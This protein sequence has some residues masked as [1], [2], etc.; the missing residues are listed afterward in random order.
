MS[1]I[2]VRRPLHNALQQAA[3]THRTDTEI[4]TNTYALMSMHTRTLMNEWIALG[5]ALGKMENLLGESTSIPTSI[6][7]T[8]QK[9]HDELR[10]MCYEYY[11]IAYDFIEKLDE[12]MLVR[13]IPCVSFMRNLRKRVQSFVK[14]LQYD[15][16]DAY[17][18]R[19]IYP[20]FCKR[21]SKEIE[22]V[23]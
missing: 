2:P 14:Q 17:I 4:Q 15:T 6:M 8:H 21:L 3:R 9:T 5:S 22:Y 20:V 10:M 19:M 1:T 7:T 12:N 13:D 16:N 23:R 11:W 18:M